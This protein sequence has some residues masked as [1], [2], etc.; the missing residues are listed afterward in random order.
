[1]DLSH[2]WQDTGWTEEKCTRADFRIAIR[3]LSHERRLK[4][5]CFGP[6]YSS[7]NAGD[8]P[9]RRDGPKLAP[10]SPLIGL[11]LT[12]KYTDAQ[13]LEDVGSLV[14]CSLRPQ[15]KTPQLEKTTA[16]DRLTRLNQQSALFK[17]EVSF[18]GLPVLGNGG[19]KSDG[20]P[21]ILGGRGDGG[22]RGLPVLGVG[23]GGG[24]GRPPTLGGGGYDG[25]GGLPVLGVG[26]GGGI[27]R[28]PILGGGG[29]DGTGGRLVLK[30]GGGGGVDRPPTQIGGGNDGTGELPVVGVGGGGGVG[31]PSTYG[32]GVRWWLVFGIGGGD[33][34][35]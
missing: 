34:A 19:G 17:G 9:E 33:G 10:P 2:K 12:E 20:R 15:A 7:D 16:G 8:G 29:Y 21:P 11:A 4:K 18:K 35:S 27:G 32:G 3:P 24:V 25:T 14:A 1:M 13:R 6:E 26:G 5:S 28:P 30:D 22:A 31:R 23:G